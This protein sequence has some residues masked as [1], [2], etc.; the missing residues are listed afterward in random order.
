MRSGGA[1]YAYRLCRRLAE[2]KVEVDVLTSVIRDPM[3]APG[4]RVHPIM[5]RWNW[6]ELLRLLRVVS[7]C[8]PDV[9]N[10]HFSGDIYHHHPMA[11]FLPSILKRLWRRISIVTLIEYPNGAQLGPICA[12]LVRKGVIALVGRKNVDWGFGTLLRDSDRIVLLSQLHLD[13]VRRLLPSVDGKCVVIP[14]PPLIELSPEEDGYRKG[15]ALLGLGAGDVLIAYYGLLYPGKGIETLL[16]AM[17]LIKSL[18]P[19]VRLILIGGANEVL[20]RAL[21][22]ENYVDELKQLAVELDISERVMFTGYYASE[23]DQ[24]SLYLRATDIAVL[25]F[26]DGIML[27]RSS[28]AAVAAHGLPIVT[29]RG[30]ALETPFIHDENVLLC[31]PRD[32]SSLASAIERTVNDGDLRRR[33]RHGARKLASEWYSWSKMVDTIQAFSRSQTMLHH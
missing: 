5:R 19:R 10:I 12:R 17:R 7:S 1:E 21:H 18:L 33:L 9:V 25:P 6:R 14:P 29:T 16:E 32:P 4:V 31:R 24:A 30:E 2:A 15:R 11:T 20:L 8:R 13:I 27:N 26:D 3:P 28:V 23:S 22:R